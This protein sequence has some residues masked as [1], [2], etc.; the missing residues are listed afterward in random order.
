MGLL[1]KV[2][3][4]LWKVISSVWSEKILLMKHNK[5]AFTCVW[6]MVPGVEEQQR[7]LLPSVSSS[8]HVVGLDSEHQASSA[9][10]P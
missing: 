2:L 9:A 1:A 3:F 6:P 10:T 4:N 8:A 5:S 7:K